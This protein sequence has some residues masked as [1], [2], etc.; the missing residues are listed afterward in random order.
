MNALPY[1]TPDLPGTGGLL[2]VRPEDFVVDEIPAYAASGDGEHLIIRIRKTGMSTFQAID[3]IA[4]VAKVN[5]RDI[6]FAGLKDTQAV[7]RQYLTLPHGASV[8]T[9]QA[10]ASPGLSVESVDR[11]HNKL[12][13][14]HLKG[15]RFE[16]KVREVEPGLI[17]RAKPIVDQLVARG[18]PNYFGEQRFGRRGDND[19]LGAALLRGD[20]DGLLRLL[21]GAPKNDVDPSN[22]FEAR[23]FFERG[24]LKAAMHKWPRSSGME[25]RI[26]AR[27]QKTNN[28]AQSVRL[29]EPKLRRLWLSALQSRVFNEV[30]AARI[31]SIGTV[32]PGDLAMLHEKGACFSVEDA[33]ADQARAD[34]FEI[35]ATGPMLGYRM[36]LPTGEPLAIEQSVFDRFGLTREDFKRPDRDQA[37]GDR[38]ALRVPVRE[39]A[40][41]S[42]SDAHGGYLSVHFTLPAGSFGTVVLR[43]I[44]KAETIIADE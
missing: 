2:R 27:F 22:I 31:G 24:D 35:S 16:I 7:T 33:S 19:L 37:K 30:V 13:P 43:E 5:P 14:G 20:A 9:V 10:I 42:G 8:E 1:L 6:G 23:R 11:H 44:M 17:E 36:T 39:A 40:I 38:R 34:V 21:I 18:L 29:V 15:N 26:L 12:R 25:R 28:A 4:R 41:E 32:L 3:R